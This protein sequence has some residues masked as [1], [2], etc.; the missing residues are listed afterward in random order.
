MIKLDDAL[1]SVTALCFDTSPLIYFIERHPHYFKTVREIFRRVDSTAI[2]GYSSVI[3]LT[4]VLTQPKRLQNPT[5]ESEYRSLLLYS[6][7]FNLIP[8]DYSIAE[9]AASLRARYRLRTPDALQLAVA[10]NS[11]CEAFLTNDSALQRVTE[12]RVLVIDQL[13]L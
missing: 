2:A 1:S 3:T 13:E 8:I 10:F 6:H 4:E 12:L 7:N 9:S 5:V 11:G